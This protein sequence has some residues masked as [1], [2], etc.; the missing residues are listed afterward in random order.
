MDG[1]ELFLIVEAISNEKNIS[2]E[3]VFISLEEALAVATR[4]KKVLMYRSTLIERLVI[5]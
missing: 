2:K 5:M 4:K 1:K 3:E